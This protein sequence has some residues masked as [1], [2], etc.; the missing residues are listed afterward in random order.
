MH[1][2]V[3]A[4]ELVINEI[5][6]VITV[7]VAHP[8]HHCHAIILPVQYMFSIYYFFISVL[9]AN[10]KFQFFLTL[11]AIAKQRRIKVNQPP[12]V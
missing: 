1:F 3:I 11:V 5:L 9:I 2:N 12:I 4:L 10:I 6:Y 7:Y 8:P